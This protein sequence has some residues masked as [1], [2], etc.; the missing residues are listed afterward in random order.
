MD[1]LDR[2]Y[3]GGRGLATQSDPQD[4]SVK[5]RAQRYISHALVEVRRFRYLPFFCHS[6]VLLDIS[7]GGFKL[8]FTGEIEVAPGNQYWLHVPL[9]PLGIPHPKKIMCLSECR[10]FDRSRFRIGGTF[11]NLSNQDRQII[12][13]IVSSLKSR[14]QI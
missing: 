6:A 12:D 7:T 4:E 5:P 9:T 13:Q 2:V 3:K 8:E 1:D 14:G 11:I 10:W